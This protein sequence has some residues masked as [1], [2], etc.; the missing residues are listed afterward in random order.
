M[1]LEDIRKM[2]YEVKGN[3]I[4]N[5]LD[6]FHYKIRLYFPYGFDRTDLLCYP[7]ISMFLAILDS[8]FTVPVNIEYE[9]GPNFTLI[10]IDTFNIN[11]VPLALGTLFNF[12]GSIDIDKL[13]NSDNGKSLFNIFLDENQELYNEGRYSFLN[14]NGKNV[15][16]LMKKEY[17]YLH[18]K[19][20]D[21]IKE[22]LNKTKSEFTEEKAII[23]LQGREIS[24][25]R[26]E[27]S[28]P[29]TYEL[30][31]TNVSYTKLNLVDNTIGLLFNY[32]DDKNP[33]ARYIFN[34]VILDFI[35]IL[36]QD[37]HIIDK[38][39]NEIFYYLVLQ[40]SSIADSIF[41]KNWIKINILDNLEDMEKYFR[42]FKILEMK[43]LIE[44][45]EGA[46]TDIDKLINIFS[47]ND[48]LFSQDELQEQIVNFQEINFK[49]FMEN[50]LI[51]LDDFRIALYGNDDKGDDE[52]GV[53]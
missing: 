15:P 4:F 42:D 11:N 32:G 7:Y 5:E 17:T 51:T 41:S 48:L 43:K 52:D 2:G 6:T 20:I 46:Y 19:S 27:A 10:K 3:F 28:K 50:V 31:N 22:K 33:R 25:L 14:V 16:D 39:P 47:S 49:E 26:F 37:G 45:I 13:F 21:E 1:K 30:S 29:I 53:I 35:S 24:K 18:E 9:V 12:M 34:R 40:D 36:L 44:E 23:F 8:F 38:S